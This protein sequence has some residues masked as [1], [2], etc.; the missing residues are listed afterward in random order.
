MRLTTLTDVTA[1]RMH[2]PKWAVSP[3]SGAGA[4]KH[5]GRAN[6]PLLI[7]PEGTALRYGSQ[8]GKTSTATGVNCGLTKGSSLLAGL[9]QIWH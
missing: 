2:A 5:G 3:S 6:R 1:Y 7:S 4:G 9:Q 8:F